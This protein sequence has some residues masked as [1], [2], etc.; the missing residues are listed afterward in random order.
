LKDRQPNIRFTQ[1]VP[2]KLNFAFAK[3]KEQPAML[4]NVDCNTNRLILFFSP[5][6]CIADTIPLSLKTMIYT[7][8][9]PVLGVKSL[10]KVKKS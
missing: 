2:A 5:H 9:E 3:L 10:C 7:E 4:V 6:T 1:A 8:I